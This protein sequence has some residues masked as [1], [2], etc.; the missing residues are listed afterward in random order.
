MKE[1]YLQKVHIA[2]SVFM[3]NTIK[4]PLKAQ[5]AHM[6]SGPSYGTGDYKRLS[7]GDMQVYAKNKL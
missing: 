7:D 6:I 4:C 3:E 2:Y 5:F 1:T